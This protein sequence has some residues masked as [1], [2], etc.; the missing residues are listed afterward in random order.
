MLH[1]GTFLCIRFQITHKATWWLCAVRIPEI[2]QPTLV[3]TVALL[4]CAAGGA[5]SRKCSRGVV[6]AVRRADDGW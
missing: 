1:Q 6:A 3:Y 2:L 5:G 4:V